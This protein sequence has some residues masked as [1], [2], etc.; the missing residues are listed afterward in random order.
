MRP[1]LSVELSEFVFQE[2]PLEEVGLWLGENLALSGLP[3]TV[4]TGLGTL[5][6]QSGTFS[7]T[8][9]GASSGTNTGDQDLS[10]YATNSGVAGAY[11]PL[12][13]T[14]NGQALSSNVTITTVSGNAGTA[15][16]LATARTI[17]GVSFDGTGNITVTAAAGTLTGTTL[18]STVVS[19]SLTS[20]GTLA[21]LTV[22]ATITGSVSGNAGTVSTINGLISQGTNVTITGSGTSGSPYVIASSGGGGGMTNPMTTAG[23][24]IYGGASGTPTRLAIADSKQPNLILGQ[25]SGIPAYVPV[26]QET[27]KMLVLNFN[28]AADFTNATAGAAGT[29]SADSTSGF[30]F[31]GPTMGFN[32]GTTAGTS[33]TWSSAVAA[34]STSDNNSKIS[35]GKYSWISAG[36]MF[37][38]TTLPDGTNDYRLYMGLVSTRTNIATVPD[39]GVYI[40]WSSAGIEGVCRNATSETKLTLAASPVAG[41]HRLQW[42]WTSTAAYFWY[43]GTYIGSITT[44]LPGTTQYYDLGLGAMRTVG[45]TA[46]FIGVAHFGVRGAF[47]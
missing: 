24:I 16:A 6:T 31:P 22:T 36:V 10:S 28:K 7:G 40:Q 43:D 8:H 11:V 5:A 19:S 4:I 14:V 20:V 45:S 9:S 35:L 30:G 41:A 1:N 21:A 39:H 42:S 18:N 33:A 38:A 47:V 29:L 15:T 25:V 44:N 32:P 26:G 17:N 2:D 12:T 37:S 46:R 13:R 27:G 34:S 3:Y 23:D